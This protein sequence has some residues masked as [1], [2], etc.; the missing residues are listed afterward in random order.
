MSCYI[1]HLYLETLKWFLG[2][3]CN[4]TALY[5]SLQ[6]VPLFLAD[7]VL[8]F[9]VL[10]DGLSAPR[11]LA[12]LFFLR[13]SRWISSRHSSSREVSV[14]NEEFQPLVESSVAIVF[15]WEI[16]PDS[17]NV[18]IVSLSLSQKK[19]NKKKRKG[20]KTLEIKG[21]MLSTR[22]IIIF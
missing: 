16:A 8:V 2:R 20:T 6:S 22:N 11:F 15:V 1:Y 14:V 4:G 12:V 18:N 7:G 19:E 21:S 5:A 17:A 3:K 10:N 9:V 13:C